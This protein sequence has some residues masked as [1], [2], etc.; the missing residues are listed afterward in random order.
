M[1]RTVYLKTTDTCNLNCSHCFTGGTRPARYF[2][3]TDKVIDWFKRFMEHIPKND[4]VHIE[5]HGGEPFLEKVENIRKVTNAIR[6]IAGDRATIGATSNLTFKLKDELLDFIKNDLDGFGTSW[7]PDIRFD[8][9]KQFELWRKNTKTVVDS[10]GGDKMTLNVSVSRVVT[11]MDQKELIKFLNSIGIKRVLF[12][13]IT[14]NGN[15]IENQHLFPSN[16]EINDWYLKM[17]KATEELD[18]RK[19]FHNA[20]L[21]DVYA[22][23]ENGM[24]TCGT[25]C[26]D[27]EERNITVNADGTI[28][29]CPNSAP[30]ENFG[31]IDMGIAELFVSARRLDVMAS[32]RARNEK[33]FEC[34]VFSYC[35]SDCHR[36]LWDGDICASPRQLMKKLA[37]QEYESVSTVR[38]NRIIPI[39]AKS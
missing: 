5:L 17:H 23:F 31:N 37:G 14:L 10:R 19:W 28:G 26:R 38:K 21:E 27:C 39:Y 22:K 24:A 36:L 16:S 35:G 29:G 2:W 18:A 11:E 1:L 15:A 34:S 6:E 4:E 30:E 25:F 32:E 8:N 33:C 12:D 13:R 3:D 20:A 7:D 9:E